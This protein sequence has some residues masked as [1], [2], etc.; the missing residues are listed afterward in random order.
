MRE[1]MP[2][3]EIAGHGA[4][5]TLHFGGAFVGFVDGSVRW[6]RLCAS[7]DQQVVDQSEY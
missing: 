5:R 6:Q 3:D 1:G 4:I 2:G 7:D